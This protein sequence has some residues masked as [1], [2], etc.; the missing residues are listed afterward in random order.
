[1]S[2]DSRTIG[3]RIAKAR[4]EAG[5][6][7]ALKFSIAAGLK[8]ATIANIESGRKDTVDIDTLIAVCR[9]TGKPLTEFVPELENYFPSSA[10]IKKQELL[11]QLREL[12]NI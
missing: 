3:Q 4:R 12:E 8:S 11:R 2:I 1:M 5:Y 6:S 10:H 9:I 7:T